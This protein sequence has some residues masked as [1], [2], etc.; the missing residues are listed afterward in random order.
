MDGLSEK[1]KVGVGR[2]NNF[3]TLGNAYARMHGTRPATIG[4]VLSSSPIALLAWSVPR[5]F[6]PLLKLIIVAGSEKSCNHGQQTLRRSTNSWTP[7]HFTGS[8]SHFL[9]LSSHIV[10]SLVRTQH[11]STT[12]QTTTSRSRWD[13][14]GI[15]KNWRLC[16]RLGPRR[17]ATWYGIKSTRKEDTS[18]RG[19]CQ[20]FSWQILNLL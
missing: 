17:R 14:R 2:Y 3:G 20:R 11:S 18:L 9:E 1:E 6:R 7:S 4:L 10:N 8:P 12:I 13:I 5:R 15:R 16:Q 19:K